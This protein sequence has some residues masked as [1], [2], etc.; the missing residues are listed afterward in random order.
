MIQENPTVIYDG[1]HNENGIEALTYSIK[2]YLGDTPKVVV[3]ACMKDKEISNSLKM[4]GEGDTEF[5]FT[6]VKNNERAAKALE[7]QARAQICGYSGIA[8]EDI[9][10]AYEYALSRNKTVIVC[11]SLY[12]Y[13]DFRNFIDKGE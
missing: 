11:G 3:F 4:L 10:E 5:V 2:R 6:T 1:G 9:G 8:Y 7:T 13:K 12:L